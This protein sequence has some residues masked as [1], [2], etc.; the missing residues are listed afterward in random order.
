[1]AR[2]DEKW[3][4]D[5]VSAVAD[6]RTDTAGMDFAAFSAKPAIVR[7]VRVCFDAAASRL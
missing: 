4:E 3:V 2:G 5:I 7:S 1:M 6:I